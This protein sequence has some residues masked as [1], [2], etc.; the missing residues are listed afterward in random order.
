MLSLDRD[1]QTKKKILPYMLISWCCRLK[2]IPAKDISRPLVHHSLIII[3]SQNMSDKIHKCIFPAAG[4]GTRFL[5][6]TKSSPKEMLPIVNKP[7]I[8]YGVAE[9]YEAD[10]K[11]IMFI[12][13]RNKESIVNYFDINF[14]L[15]NHIKGTQKEDQL[16]D[17]RELLKNCAFSYI[18]QGEIK[19]LGHAILTAHHHVENM[20]F[21]VI[22][23]DDLCLAPQGKGVL[24]Q[25]H[26]I[27][28]QEK[29][30]IIALQ[31]VLPA[32][33]SHYGIVDAQQIDD[34]LYE[35]KSMIEKPSPEKAPSQLAIIG[36]YILVPSIFSYLQKIKPGSNKE[37][38]ITDALAE[39]AKHERVIG[40]KINATHFDCG[41]IEGFV[42]ATSYVFS[43]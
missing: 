39:Q 31:E 35:I 3:R 42:Q 9:S 8:H 16:S 20:P 28:K 12:V 32:E 25:M 6:V 23:S 37:Y 40:L 11:D 7:L 15:E 17:L 27:Y 4:Y 38:Q 5:P 26:E 30:T 2:R 14:E 43:N 19:G 24:H 41:N 10:I 29:C 36:R 22:L 34:R 21:A 33:T 1:Q 13:G 18:R